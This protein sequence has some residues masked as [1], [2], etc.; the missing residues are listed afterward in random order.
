V[1]PYGSREVLVLLSSLSTCDPGNIL[2][3]VKATKA[4]NVR[5]SII[6]LSAEMYIS[7][8]MCT[9]TGGTYAVATSKEHL[10]ELTMQ[11]C[12]PPAVQAVRALPNLVRMAFP[13]K[14]AE[15]DE[16]AAFVGDACTIAGGAFTCPVCQ[17]KNATIPCD[18]HVCGI[19]LISSP[20]LARSYHHLFP[21]A[22]FAEVGLDR[23]GGQTLCA[24]CH[25]SLRGSAASQ[26]LPGNSVA[27]KC[28][29]C[30]SVCCADCDEFV[31][32]H[33]HNCPGCE[34]GVPT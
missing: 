19:T 27:Y 5:V 16:N 9:D 7:Q 28:P 29:R 14:D 4:A 24:F 34:A 1:P 3:A 20:H 6:G 12:T 10:D 17:A 22:G 30:C 15:G 23:I 25:L 18:C 32:E 31:H 33:L 2:D 26:I 21:I 8:K 13:N 11:M